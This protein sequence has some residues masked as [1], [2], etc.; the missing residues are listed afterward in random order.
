MKLGRHEIDLLAVK[1]TKDR[2][3]CRHI[4]VQAS[5]SPIGYVTHAPGSSASIAKRRS[6]EELQKHAREW[7]RHKFDLPEKQLARERL[8][9]GHWSRELVVNEVKYPDELRVITGEGLNVLY[10]RD[11]VNELKSKS[12]D[13][14]GASGAHLVDLITLSS[15]LGSSLSNRMDVRR[16]SQPD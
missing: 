13:F 8:A 5:V 10:L 1:K 16:A 12:M 4:E 6:D 7:V 9:A 15:S 3:E 14:K 2:L 11:L